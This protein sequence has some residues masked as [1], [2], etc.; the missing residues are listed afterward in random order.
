MYECIIYNTF[1]P[2]RKFVTSFFFSFAVSSGIILCVTIPQHQGLNVQ[3][4]GKIQYG[5]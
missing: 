4:Q 5:L 3:K 1:D 2:K